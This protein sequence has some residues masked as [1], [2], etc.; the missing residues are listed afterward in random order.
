MEQQASGRNV[1]PHCVKVEARPRGQ[2]DPRVTQMAT[3]TVSVCQEREHLFWFEPWILVL[4]LR[5]GDNRRSKKSVKAIASYWRLWHHLES[6]KTS[7]FVI[8]SIKTTWNAGQV[9]S[10]HKSNNQHNSMKHCL[11]P[12]VGKHV[13]VKNTAR[14]IRNRKVY[15]QIQAK[16]HCHLADKFT[17]QVYINKFH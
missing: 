3:V 12:E 9:Y 7:H 2:H 10:T 4:H 17:S 15:W 5:S 1:A 13:T 11:A 8:L 6:N 14:F 16:T